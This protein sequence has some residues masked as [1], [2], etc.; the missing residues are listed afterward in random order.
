MLP[1][2]EASVGKP[3]IALVLGVIWLVAVP[4]DLYGYP[5]APLGWI[6]IIWAGVCLIGEIVANGTARAQANGNLMFRR[7]NMF[8]PSVLG[9]LG[10]LLVVY[11]PE[12]L[13]TVP[14]HTVGWVIVA[15]A[16]AWLALEAIAN[17]VT[18]ARRRTRSDDGESGRPPIIVD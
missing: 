15:G 5:T 7:A 9:A 17:G 4:A 18:R 1:F 2:R 11:A 12:S 16:V 13:G 10:S 14:V 6:V 3:I 8:S